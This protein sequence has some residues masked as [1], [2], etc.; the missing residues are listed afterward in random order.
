V[1]SIRVDVVKTMPT[2]NVRAMRGTAA[3]W[4]GILE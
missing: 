2:E 1:F 3:W 4:E